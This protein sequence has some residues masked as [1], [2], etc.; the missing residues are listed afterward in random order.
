M[1][2][3]ARRKDTWVNEIEVSQS[4]YKFDTRRLIRINWIKKPEYE[5]M[6]DVCKIFSKDIIDGG[7]NSLTHPLSKVSRKSV[8]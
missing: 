5:K 2:N 8:S 1:I 6:Q 4:I 3:Y 7:N